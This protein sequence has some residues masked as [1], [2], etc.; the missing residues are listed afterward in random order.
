MAIIFLLL[1][2]QKFCKRTNHAAAARNER[3][4][5][6]IIFEIYCLMLN[7]LYFYDLAN[8]LT[9]FALSLEMFFLLLFLDVVIYLHTKLIYL[10][11]GYGVN[12]YQN[13]DG[14]D[15]SFPND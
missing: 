13:E 15:I 5:Y 1:C 8:A 7:K 11:D 14:Q 2:S 12:Q 3:I 6:S 4:N 10:V 9:Y